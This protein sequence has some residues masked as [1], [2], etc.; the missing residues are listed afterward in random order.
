M[1]IGDGFQVRV[2]KLNRI[3]A[4]K[5]QVGHEK[6]LAALPIL[7][8]TLEEKRRRDASASRTKPSQ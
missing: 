5:E 6:D 2:M 4:V 1:Q 3:I 7:R 8:R